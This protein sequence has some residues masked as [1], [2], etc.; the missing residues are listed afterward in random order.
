MP[1][2]SL[3]KSAARPSFD[4]ERHERAGAKLPALRLS[5]APQWDDPDQ[6]D[7]EWT[8]EEPGPATG[9]QLEDVAEDEEFYEG[10][11]VT[12]KDILLGARG[13]VTQ[14]DLLGADEPE[15][16]TFEWD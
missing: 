11:S 10:H 8:D 12:L 6:Q 7:T 15:D 4:I 9:K 13:D 14:F 3:K 2:S 5:E 1:L 16:E